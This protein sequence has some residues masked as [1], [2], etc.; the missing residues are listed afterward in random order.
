MWEICEGVWCGRSV[1]VCS[2][3]DVGMCVVVWEM[4][5]GVSPKL[6]LSLHYVV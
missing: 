4:G 2:V 3:G 1:R 6:M 5:E